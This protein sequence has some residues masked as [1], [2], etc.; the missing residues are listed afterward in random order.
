MADHDFVEPEHPDERTSA[1]LRAFLARTRPLVG[2]H[3]P[4]WYWDGRQL[5]ERLALH[6][7]VGTQDECHWGADECAE[8]LRYIT[9]VQPVD[10]ACFCNDQSALNATCG[11]HA[12]LDFVIDAIEALPKL[13]AEIG[14][15]EQPQQEGVHG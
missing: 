10:G 12:L 3:V 11:F 15:R 7:E 5:I 8:V 13:P 2:N 9:L 6:Y 4:E 1:R 14:D